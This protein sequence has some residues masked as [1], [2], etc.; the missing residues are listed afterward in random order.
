L[1]HST[2]QLAHRAGEEHNQR[3]AEQRDQELM[4]RESVQMP[5]DLWSWCSAPL[6]QLPCRS[7][8]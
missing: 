3:Q 5:P 1:T 6:T 7:R 8:P 4:F 2:C